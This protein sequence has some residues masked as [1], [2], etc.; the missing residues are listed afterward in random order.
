MPLRQSHGARGSGARHSPI[1]FAFAS[2]SA[3][4]YLRRSSGICS[5][6]YFRYHHAMPASSCAR[7]V[8]SELLQDRHSGGETI[9]R[10]TIRPKRSRLVQTTSTSCPYASLARFSFDRWPNGWDFS[11][12]SI[13]DRRILCSSRAGPS[14]VTV[15]PSVSRHLAS[16]ANRRRL[17]QF[18]PAVVSAGVS[19]LSSIAKP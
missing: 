18:L 2:A 14:T 3:N 16:P 11:G 8:S 12:A 10:P 19:S 7:L 13:P 17:H 9:T 1:C 15:S 4:S 5:G 6:A